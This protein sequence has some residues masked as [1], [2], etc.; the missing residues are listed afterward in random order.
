MQRGGGRQVLLTGRRRPLNDAGRR[1]PRRGVGRRAAGV[2][3]AVRSETSHEADATTVHRGQVCR[4]GS[5]WTTTTAARLEER[6]AKL[7]RRSVV[8]DRIH[9]RVEVGQTVPH[10]THR[11]HHSSVIPSSS[12]PLLLARSQTV[13]RIADRILP[14]S[15]LSSD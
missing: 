2:A 1:R 9:T 12:Y 11:L 4:D 6:V 5:V 3:T 7:L 13:A 14:H 10:H 15:R 8:D